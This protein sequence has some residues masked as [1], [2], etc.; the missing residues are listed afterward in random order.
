MYKLTALCTILLHCV[1]SYR[2]LTILLPPTS[3]GPWKLL[4]AH[5]HKT[6]YGPP[7]DTA[8]YVMFL[9]WANPLLGPLEE[10]IEVNLKKELYSI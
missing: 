1:Q 2:T 6:T 8:L 4:G 9:I 7:I 5:V 3:Y 10:N